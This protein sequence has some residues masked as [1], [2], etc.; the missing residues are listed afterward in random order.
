MQWNA[1]SSPEKNI[2]FWVY[3]YKLPII[4]YSALL[5]Y[6]Y[7][8]VIRYKVPIRFPIL[9]D[10]ARVWKQ[11]NIII[12]TADVR[13]LH[14][15]ICLFAT[16]LISYN[17]YMYISFI[18]NCV[19]HFCLSFLQMIYKYNTQF[20]GWIQCDNFKVIYNNNNFLLNNNILYMN[21]VRGVVVHPKR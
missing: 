8:Y 17:I 18:V 12:S 7:Y 14:T 6:W 10:R 1:S 20:S 11:V 4:L 5:Y 21:N 3:H 2:M 15:E 19:C 9:S 16:R 13:P